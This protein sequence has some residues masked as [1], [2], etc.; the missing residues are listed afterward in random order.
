MNEYYVKKAAAYMRYQDFPGKDTTI[1]FIHGLGCASSFEYPQVVAQKELCNHRRILVDLL[2]AGYSDKPLDF[3]YSVSAHAE[4]VKN[5][6]YDLD[7]KHFILFGH[8]LGGPVAIE[9][10]KLCADKVKCLILSE[11]NLDPSVEGASSYSIARF[12]EK[13][14]VETGFYELIEECKKSGNTMWAAS[15]ANWAPF[16][17]YR[18]SQSAVSGGNPSWRSL[19]YGL[20]VQ[21]GFIFGEESLPDQDYE[22]LKQQGIHVE[23][24]LNA[25]HSMAWDNPQGLSF[26]ISQCLEGK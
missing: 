16:A 9:L 23:T 3:E 22:E 15:L 24:V 17:A 21:R 26:A 5:F 12:S 7:L 2:G 1:L 6:V 18:F 13:H 14:F 11:A 4:Y 8:S 10:S 25:G 19:L 20:P